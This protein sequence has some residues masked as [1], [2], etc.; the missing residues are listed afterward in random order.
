MSLVAVGT[1]TIGAL[2]VTV[3]LT[4]DD[5]IVAVL[6]PNGAGKTTLLRALAGLQPLATG[7]L[8]LDGTVLDDPTA[9]V[10]VRPADRSLGMVFQDALLFPHLSVT[11]NLTL[12]QIRVLGR[13][14]DDAKARGLKMLPDAAFDR[15]FSGWARKQRRGE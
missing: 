12:A 13:T 7:R 4:V 8:V 15:L 5:E 11:E 6:G 1:V 9:G 14:P 3:D 10:F 2:T